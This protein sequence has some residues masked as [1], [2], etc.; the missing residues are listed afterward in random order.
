MLKEEYKIICAAYDQN[1]KLFDTLDEGFYEKNN[2]GAGAD[3]AHMLS[4]TLFSLAVGIGPDAYFQK[5]RDENGFFIDQ[6]Y[7]LFY[8]YTRPKKYK[9]FLDKYS[10]LINSTRLK[11]HEDCQKI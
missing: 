6:F 11:M 4:E 3:A 10:Y 8:P 7:E 1:D 5:Y 2:M 9:K